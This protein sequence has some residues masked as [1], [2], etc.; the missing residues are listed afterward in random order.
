MLAARKCILILMLCIVTSCMV[1]LKL[2]WLSYSL[3]EPI[4]CKLRILSKTLIAIY[5]AKMYTRLWKLE[6]FYEK[7]TPDVTS[8]PIRYPYMIEYILSSKIERT[9]L[10]YLTMLTNTNNQSNYQ[11]N[12]ICKCSF[13]TKLVHFMIPMKYKNDIKL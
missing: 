5:V 7:C 9:I 2:Y 10:I 12:S 3:T 1:Q 6:H 8:L 13:I 11:Y 4:W